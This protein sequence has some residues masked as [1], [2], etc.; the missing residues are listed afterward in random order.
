MTTVSIAA[1]RLL[2]AARPVVV[3][4]RIQPRPAIELSRLTRY[5]GGTYSHTVDRIVFTDGTFARTDLIR[6]NPGVDA[7]SLDFTG[8]APLRPSRYDV[9]SFAALPNARAR[10][11]EVE[12]DWI[13]RNSFPRLRTAELSRRLRDAGYPLGAGHIGEHE[14]I[15]ATQGAI[16]HFTNGL[17]LDTR[18]RNRPNRVVHDER[19]VTVEFADDIELDGYTVDVAGSGPVTVR[20][21]KSVDGQR[22]DEVAASALTAGSGEH[23]KPLGVGATVSHGH[24]HTRRGHR[25]YRLTVDGPAT[26][27]DT[28]FSLAGCA[29]YRNSPR[30]V[31][32]YRYLIEG[33][34]RARAHSAA[35]AVGAA[36]VLVTQDDA[37]I[38]PFRLCAGSAAALDGDG[39]QVVDADGTVIDGPLEPGAAFYLS[40]GAHARARRSVTLTV[41]VPGRSD[42]HGGRVLTG[43]AREE[44]SQRFTPVALV[45]PTQ[46]VVEFD[47]AW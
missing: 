26:I 41:K 9:E 29:V 23:H 13:L 30:I 39:A 24:G 11:F 22:W 6:L 42:G 36:G 14:A 2:P 21:H 17:E 37:V 1:G 44:N 18:P 5:H 38:G 47:L 25:H 43:V 46:S 4:R 34:R 10:S 28:A 16:W 40:L 19:G 7:Y 3:R 15:A 27:G 12:I 8:V 31:H 32:A 20:L 33:A 35:P 45:V